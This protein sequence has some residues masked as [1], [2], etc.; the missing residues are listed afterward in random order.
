MPLAR[1]QLHREGK[2]GDLLVFID[3]NPKFDEI[4]GHQV[5]YLTAEFMAIEA[6]KYN[7]AIAIAACDL[8][9]RIAEKIKFTKYTSLW[10]I[11]ADNIVVLDHVDVRLRRSTM[12]FCLSNVKYQNR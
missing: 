12:C 8:R 6:E 11:A 9:K 7:I 5:Y 1:N 4:N 3:D 10:Q 2:S